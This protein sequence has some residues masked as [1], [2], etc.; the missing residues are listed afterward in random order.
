MNRKVNKTQ[1]NRPKTFI[2]SKVWRKAH[3]IWP[4]DQ[5]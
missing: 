2:E 3:P 1:I 5:F 4:K